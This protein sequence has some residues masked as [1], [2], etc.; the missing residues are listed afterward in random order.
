[1]VSSPPNVRSWPRVAAA[2]LILVGATLRPASA[3]ESFGDYMFYAGDPHS[4]TGVSGDGSASDMGSGCLS[5]GALADV[6]EYAA[7]QGLDWVAFSDHSNDDG[8]T[9]NAGPS[10]FS[11]FWETQL[12]HDDDAT[13]LVI[14]PSAEVWFN[15]GGSAIGHRNL[16]MFGDDATLTGFTVFDA[17]PN[18]DITTEIGTCSAMEAWMDTVT[19]SWGD[20]L[21]IPHHPYGIAP[22][23]MDWSCHSDTYEP[24][25]EV[26]SLWGNSLGWGRS[27]EGGGKGGGLAPP[28]RGEQRGGRDGQ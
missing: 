11:D 5:C 7:V 26:Y 15:I 3:S 23:P 19:A 10:D 27:S 4:H 18:G 2:W 9:R 28:R 13:G 20:A 8:G 6:F 14:V 22:A 16:M 25:V 21:L 12:A 17:T 1:M 24:A